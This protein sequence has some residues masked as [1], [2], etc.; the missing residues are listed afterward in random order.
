[1]RETLARIQEL[2]AER[3]PHFPPRVG[4][5]LLILG[6][7]LSPNRI[8]ILGARDSAEALWLSPAVGE[9]RIIIPQGEKQAKALQEELA[10]LKLGD[11]VDVV[12][13]DA[14][15][16]PTSMRESFPLVILSASPADRFQSLD[17]LESLLAKGGLLTI[18]GDGKETEDRLH[19]T[20]GESNR[21][22][23]ADIPFEIELTLAVSTAG[24]TSPSGDV[25]RLLMEMELVNIQSREENWAVKLRPRNLHPESARLLHLMTLATKPKQILEIGTSTGYSTIWLGLAA[26]RVEATVAGTEIDKDK[27]KIAT[28]NIIRA[29]LGD[30]VRVLGGDARMTLRELSGPYELVF[31]DADKED[32]LDYLHLIRPL[33]SARGLVL[34]DNVHSHREQ[35]RPYLEAIEK[36]DKLLSVTLPVGAGLEMTLNVGS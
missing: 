34:A 1:M 18:I 20:L 11:V 33:L 16:F 7:A 12:T 22:F 36:D 10:A 21:L 6:S 25:D 4:R 35:C 24:D 28:E 29:G 14:R 3:F 8:L 27:V 2:S 15:G 9:G 26:R 30:T 23:T 17:L 13:S 19:K 31:L 5:F 32:Y